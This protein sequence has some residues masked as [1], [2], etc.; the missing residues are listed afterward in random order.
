MVKFGIISD[1]HIDGDSD[2]S[3]TKILIEQLKIVFKD[4]NKILHAG[5]VNEDFFLDELKKIAPTKCVLGNSDNIKDLKE[6]MKFSAGKYNIG[7]IHKP[8]QNME[9]F[10]KENNLH[11]LIHGHTHIPVIKGT[12]YKTLIL[13]PGSPIHPKPPPKKPMFNEPIARPSVMTLEIDEHE[14]LKTFIINLKI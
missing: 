14:I 6:F 1:T 5:D 11:I 3:K 9:V 7:I 2:P 8:P 12:Q 4:V 13:N 10:F